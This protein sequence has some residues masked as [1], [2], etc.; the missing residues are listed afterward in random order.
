MSVCLFI[1]EQILKT[2][3]LTY[4]HL[5]FV[6]TWLVKLPVNIK[7]KLWNSFSHFE[8]IDNFEISTIVI[9]EWN[10]Y[11]QTNY[12]L[13]KYEMYGHA[14]KTHKSNIENKIADIC[15]MS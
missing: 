10:F 9:S 15:L 1:L 6:L 7:V 3:M 8:N 5:F 4:Y 2:N 12:T 11:C 14:P 13:N